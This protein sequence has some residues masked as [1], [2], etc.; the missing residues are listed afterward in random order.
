MHIDSFREVGTGMTPPMRGIPAD[1]H[2]TSCDPH[3][4]N[5]VT[6]IPSLDSHLP[7][8]SR[9]DRISQPGSYE[10]RLTE[11]TETG[12]PRRTVRSSGAFGL[13]LPDAMPLGTCRLRRVSRFGSGAD[14]AIACPCQVA[15]STRIGQGITSFMQGSTLG[16]DCCGPGGP[17][18]WTPSGGPTALP[19]Y[20]PAGAGNKDME[21]RSPRNPLIRLHFGR[22]AR[23]LSRPSAV[24]VATF[25]RR[26][27]S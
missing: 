25:R 24:R 26:H 18:P 22:P 8:A 11:M 19:A 12:K 15:C 20:L 2:R 14:A 5:P 17:R 3:L 10:D 9:T 27:A 6:R 7:Y 23:A 13:P 16:A 21:N 1:A 4:P